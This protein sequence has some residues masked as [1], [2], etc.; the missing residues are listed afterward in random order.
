MDK[1]IILSLLIVALI[2]I[3]AATYQINNGVENLNPL[4]NVAV[5]ENPVT[6]TL[7]APEQSN[8]G[9]QA[10]SQQEQQQQQQQQQQPPVEESNV[11]PSTPNNEAN[12]DAAAQTTSNSQP[13]TASSDSEHVEGT[14]NNGD[15]Q[16]QNNPQSTVTVNDNPT[17]TEGTND[18]SGSNNNQNGNNNQ[19]D[20][21]QNNNN[22]NNNNN[23]T[24]T[25]NNAVE[26]D[27]S[28]NE[29]NTA[30]LDDDGEVLD[31][32][33]DASVISSSEVFSKLESFVQTRWLQTEPVH[34]DNAQEY[35]S[36]SG[37][38]YYRYDI[39]RDSDNSVV[40]QASFNRRTGKV[41]MMDN[42]GPSN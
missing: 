10:T 21:N 15:N 24:S 37:E 30:Q 6:Q 9:A 25:D 20:N 11:E 42:S 12:T 39:V 23:P 31:S 18:N 2:G 36:D 29:G 40:G 16:G 27:Y 22:Q 34:L 19:N 32:G 41:L 3:V 28:Q 26:P 1:K 7:A 13:Q 5:E 35:T 33:I 38:R 14:N 4:S 8:D 17:T